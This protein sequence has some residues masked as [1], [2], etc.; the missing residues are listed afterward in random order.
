MAKQP[1]KPKSAYSAPRKPQPAPKK[2]KLS[3]ALLIGIIGAVVLVF[4]GIILLANRAANAP[5]TATNRVGEGTAWGPVDAPVTV[6]DYS[7]Y[8]CSHCR[9]FAL[10]QGKQLREEYESTG[11]VR[12]EFKHMI[13]GGTATR[14]AANA[15]ECAADQGRFWDYHDA[16]FARQGTSANPFTKP[17]LKRYAAELGLD[18]AQFDPCVDRNA[19][20]NTVAASESEARAKGVNATPTFF[21]NGEKIEGARQYEQFKA[22]VDAAIAAAQ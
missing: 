7:D 19:H 5:L 16:L 3:P 11:K 4:A 13:I 21:I 22:S 2:S 10:N 9:D 8:G 18:S 17:L 1:Q 14:D 15:S 6:I 12:F 20:Y